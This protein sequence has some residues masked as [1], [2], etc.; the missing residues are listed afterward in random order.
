MRASLP[1]EGVL[2]Q[3]A[4]ALERG[5]L[6][7]SAPPGSGKTTAVPLALLQAPW[8]AGRK[9]L[10][11]ELRRPAARMAATY[12]AAQLGEKVGETVGYAMRLER[13]VGPRTRLEVITEGLLTRRLQTDPELTDVGLVI[14]DEFH[15]R[16]LQAD[17]GLALCLDVCQ[18]LRDDLR[19]LVMS[20][21]LEEE[22]VAACLGAEVVRAE[23]GSYPVEVEYLARPAGDQW[24]SACARLVQRAC[25]E[26]EGDVLVFL[27]GKG[28]IQR[29]AERLA[30]VLPEVTCLPLHGELDAAAQARVLKPPPGHPQR[31]VLATDVAETSLTIEG[32]GA[33][34]DSGLARKP[35]F[36]PNSGLSRLVLGPISQASARQRAGRAGRLGPGICLRAYTEAEFQ[37]RPAQRPAEILEQELADLVLEL[38]LWGVTDPAQLRWIDPPPRAAWAQAV[39]LLQALGA[40]D[41][42]GRITRRGRAMA[43]L[44]LHPR[45]AHLLLGGGDDPRA[46]DLAALLSHRDP[47]RGA[48][49]RPRP[50][51]LS[52]RLQAL[53]AL[54]AGRPVPPELDEQSARA[55]LHLSRRLRRR[56]GASQAGSKESAPSPA[57][58]LSLAY[59]DRI[60]R[61]RP[62]S[63]QRYL[64]ASG[65]GARLPEGDALQ[66]SEFLVVAALDA[67]QREGRIWQALALEEA[68]LHALHGHRM[69]RRE[70]LEWDADKA[71]VIRRR[72]LNLGELVLQSQVLPAQGPQVTELLMARLAE[73]GLEVLGWPDE[74]RQFQARV[75]WARR[76]EPDGPW[77]DLSDAWLLAHLDQW[78]APWAADARG[79]ADLR[80][81]DH[82]ALLQGRLD[83]G[84][85]QRLDRE[86]PARWTFADGSRAPIDYLADPPR[87]A[88]PVQRFYGLERS[89]SLWGGRL[90]LTLVLLSPAGRPVQV[91]C[92]LHRFWAGAWSEVRKSLRGRYP[93]HHWPEAPAKARPVALKRQLPK[94]DDGGTSR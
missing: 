47:W 79:F 24:L 39:G 52:L 2:P 67:G 56:L 86:L 60:A 4:R 73:A 30:E 75:A 16:A 42:E 32:I 71:Q 5:H 45:L 18:G 28:E 7:L 26:Q 46:A 82:L 63:D 17:L 14:F 80:R 91:T 21:T 48:P 49:D 37:R 89:P 55:I 20:A 68:E 43:P 93:K 29:L 41:D 6:V 70:V 1:I 78:L 51:D 57:G 27:P 22:A 33:V 90:P 31:V 61:R 40:L 25:R 94:S 19:L 36:D 50:V 44:G 77:P 81:L 69:V 11:L 59:P 74:V 54:R 87:L 10:M 15:E 62:G 38:A 85:L 58:L 9:I 8:L 64:L 72:H 88:A 35:R 83:W 84:D 53:Q 66:G 12:L 65:R 23:G 76:L 3:V 34:V 13:C 92:D